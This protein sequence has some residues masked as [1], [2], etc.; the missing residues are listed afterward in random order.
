MQRKKY[1]ADFKAKVALE[2]IKGQRSIA[3]I[4]SE[5]EVHANQISKWKSEAQAG[6]AG[7]FS[8]AII[9][10]NEA[11][12]ELKEKLYSQI[13]QLKVEID[14]LKKKTGNKY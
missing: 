9:R 14:W 1:G 13:G 4:S 5:F 12:E 11:D 6:L 8:G 7:V 3:E 2:A 10:K